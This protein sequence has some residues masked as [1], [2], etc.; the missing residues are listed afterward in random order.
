MNKFIKYFLIFAL[1]TAFSALNSAEIFHHHDCH[2]ETSAQDN[3]CQACIIHKS[4]QSFDAADSYTDFAPAYIQTTLII[5][6]SQI[7]AAKYFT[8]NTGRAPPIA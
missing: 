3:S 5:S 8:F 2:E 7:P 1:V 6:D 4:I